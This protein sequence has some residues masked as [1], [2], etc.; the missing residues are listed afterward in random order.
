MRA[1]NATGVVKSKAK[2]PQ[3]FTPLN[4]VTNPTVTTNAAAFYLDRRPQTLRKWAVC[5]TTGP[6]RPIRVNGRLSWPVSTIRKLLE[7]A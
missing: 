2:P 7:V 4:E 3:R 1:I 6:M 5:E